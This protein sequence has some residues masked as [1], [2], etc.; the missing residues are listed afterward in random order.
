MP[1]RWQTGKHHPAAVYAKQVVFGKLRPMCCK[2]EILACE[3]FLDDLERQGTEDFP[4]VFDTTRADRILEWFGRCIQIRGPYAGQ[5][6]EPQPWQVFDQSNIYGWV[7]KDTGARRFTRTYN[8][9]ARGNVKSTEVSCKCNY[10][11]CADVI[12]PPYRPEL[13]QFETAPEVECAAVDR[14]QARRVYD[15]AKA[16]ARASPGIAKP[17]GRVRLVVK[18]TKVTH[19]TRGGF[20]RALSKDTDNKDSGAPSYFEVDEYHAHKTSEIYDLGLNSFGKRRQALLDVITTAGDDAEHKPCKVEEDYCKRILEDPSVRKTEERYFVMIREIDD[21]DNPHD[22]SC[23][24]KAN[25]VI[26]YPGEYGE[27][28]LA[29]IEAEYTTA[30]GSGDAEK[31]RK[32]LTRRMCRWQAGSVNRYL[33]EQ[34][35]AAVKAAMIP[36]EEFAALTDGLPCHCGYDLGKRIDLSGVGAVFDLPDGRIGIKMH[37]FMPENGAERH[38]HTDRVPYKAWAA[39][40][41]CTLTPG[42]VT[43]NS[44]VDNW[45]CEGEREHSWKVLEVDYDGHNATDLAIK[46]CEARN[47]NDFCVEIAQTCAGL[48]AATKGFRD[49]LMNGRLVIEYSP[50]ALWCC[51]NA[52]EV[53]NNFGDIKLSK[54]H[55]DD[56]ERID[57]LAGTLNALARL[58]VKRTAKPDLNEKIMRDDWHIL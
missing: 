29:Q 28:L 22:K 40:G 8:K 25:P 56:S 30:Y 4:W 21:E 41:Y 39:D 54:K 34:Q 58:L 11:M 51:A 57:P 52:I 12:Y 18:E 42:D 19:K 33:N 43:D 3:R 1:V 13:A 48:N 24:A 46:M 44:Y 26:R 15:D 20:M 47:N 55:K 50:L 38:E 6:V 10:H 7:H 31:I 5:P 27:T 37:G 17:G 45:I 16:I 49:M 32:F 53:V 9:R 35:L 36:R 23:W 14:G 2:Y